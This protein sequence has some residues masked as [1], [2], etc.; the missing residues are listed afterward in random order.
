M[1]IKNKFFYGYWIVLAGFVTMT[2]GSGLGFY[3]FSVLNKPIGDDF[4]WSRGVVTAAFSIFIIA[5]AAASPIVGRLTD[6]RG[7]RQI[8]FLGTI[9]MSLALVLLSRTSAIWNYYL[10]HLCLGIGHALLGTIPISIIVSNWFYRWRGTMQGLAF[11]GIGFGGLALAPL[12]GNYFILN[13][14]WSD[15]YLVMAFLLLV[16]MLPLIFF[17]IKDHPHQKGLRPCGQEAAEVADDNGSIT[18]GATGLSLK[19]ALGTLTFWVVVLTAAVYGMSGT[20]GLQ[21]QVSMFTEQGFTATSAVAAIGIVGLFSAV[22]KFLFGYLCDHTNPKYA[23]AIS[24]ALIAFSLVAMIQARSTAHLWL[25]AV[26]MGL[27]QGGWAPNLAMLAVNYF[28]LRHYGVVLGAM[29]FIFMAGE[30]V[31]PMMVGFTYDQTGSYRMILIVF[32][33]LC[34][35][36]VPLVAVIRKPKIVSD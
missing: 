5:T 9:V 4:G 34:F 2:L 1:T 10:L 13:L 26:L 17:V 14:G 16:T 20:G 29:H 22:G 27:G 24:Y 30:A 8:L 28:G 7:P 23:A 18:K 35:V 33:V 12:I 11:T 21:N 32:V 15:T 36:S 6:K 31:G 19:E 3:G 25:Y